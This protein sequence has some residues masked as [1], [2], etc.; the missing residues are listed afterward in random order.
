[1]DVSDCLFSPVALA[2]LN[3]LQY[4]QAARDSY[5]LLSGGLMWPDERPQVGSP[6]RGVVSLDCAYRFLIAYRASITLGEER[7]KFRSVWE[8]VVDETPNWPGLRHERRGAA[9]RKR[10]LAAKRR[11]ARCFDE[12][13]RTMADQ[14]ANENG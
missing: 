1:M 4:D 12:L 3:S 2:V 14:R 5:E 6:E 8:Q 9:A 11:I 7:S 13:E 10:L